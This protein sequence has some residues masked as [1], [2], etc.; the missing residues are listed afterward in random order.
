MISSIFHAIVYDPLYNGL[1]F[2]VD[3]LPGHDV[4]VAIVV[5]T[6]LVRIIIY[7]L[8]K[9]AIQ[10]QMAMKKAV[11]EVEEL[12]KKFKK[13]SPEQTQAVLAYYR[14]HDIHPFA[15]LGLMLIQLPILIALYWIFAMGGLPEVNANVLYSFVPSPESI[16]MLFLGFV[17][18]GAK[19]NIPLAALT[20]LTQ[21][22]YSRLSMGPRVGQT[23]V[24]ESL[25]ADMARSFDLQVRYILPIVVG[26]VVYVVPAAAALYYV[27]SNLF[28]IV[29][30]YASGRRFN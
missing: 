7:P 10:S 15:G 3:I 2:L 24:E 11:P 25:S 16:S 5:L 30:E 20:A 8:S 14:E 21:L 17:D 29:Q 18:M 19:Y 28:M 22:V 1:M 26:F 27:T 12:K 4:G 6:L 9:R 13:N 23:A